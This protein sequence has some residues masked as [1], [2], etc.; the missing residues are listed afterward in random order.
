MRLHGM[1]VTVFAPGFGTI[2]AMLSV[3]RGVLGSATID[4]IP[5]DVNTSI[6]G[7]VR[8]DF[9]E[10]DRPALGGV[11]VLAMAGDEMIAET[12]SCELGSYDLRVPIG[13]RKLVVRITVDVDHFVPFEMTRNI[14][15]DDL[16]SLNILLEPLPGARGAVSGS[17]ES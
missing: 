14:D 12:F 11:R 16:D 13:G 10:T 4:L 5:P 6:Q 3:D 9:S 7:T 17:P 2:L 15:P 8:A 1:N